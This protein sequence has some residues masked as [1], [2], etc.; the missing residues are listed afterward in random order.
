MVEDTFL[1]LFCVWLVDGFCASIQWVGRYKNA[2]LYQLG[3]FLAD[4][5]PPCL[6]AGLAAQLGSF[7]GVLGG[8]C[9]GDI[10]G[11]IHAMDV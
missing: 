10:R 5:D 1:F 7:R 3:L 2:Y 9:F 11:L 6:L 8:V 4:P